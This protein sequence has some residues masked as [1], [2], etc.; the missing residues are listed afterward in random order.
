[1]GGTGNVTRWMGGSGEDTFVYTE[2]ATDTITDFSIS[3]A[4]GDKIDLQALGLTEDDLETIVRLANTLEADDGSRNQMNVYLNLTPGTDGTIT[5]G[6]STDFDI[7]LTGIDE[8]LAVS[9][10]I[11]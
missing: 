9:D 5:F 2:C 1:M 11:I 6:T 7:H 4:G 3:R 10:F 8:D